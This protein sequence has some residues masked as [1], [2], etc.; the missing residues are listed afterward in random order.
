MVAAS[1]ETQEIIRLIGSQLLCLAED[2][3]T[4]RMVIEKDILEFVVDQLCGRVVITLDFIA[5]DIN[6]M[7]DFMMRV[8]AVEDDVRQQVDSP[9]KVLALDGSIKDGI[10]L[11]GKGIQ[12][13]TN[14]F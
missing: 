7:F 9:R 2:V 6:L 12:V 11:V 1:D 3:M 4:Q 13:A 8:L 14:A 10:L 5:D